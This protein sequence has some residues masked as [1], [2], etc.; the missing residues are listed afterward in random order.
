MLN[1]GVLGCGPIAQFAHLEACRKARNAELYAI[2]DVAK[3][4][5]DKMAAIH[6]PQQVYDDYQ[7]MLQDARLDA[8]I[9]ATSDAFH[10]P[11]AEM[12]INA[13]KHV[14][15]EKP[16]GTSVDEVQQLKDSLK[17]SEL[18][19]QVGH[20][21]RFD[22]GFVAAKNFVDHE[23]GEGLALKAWY[24]DSIF[25]YD[26]TDA[27]QPIPFHSNQSK[28]PKEDPKSNKQ[29]Y[30][31]LAHGSHLVDT[32]RFLGGPI[33]NVRARFSRKFGAY[34]WFVEVEFVN[35]MMGHLDLTIGVRM[36]WHEGFQIYGEHGSVLGKSFNPWYY[37]SSEV[38]CFYEKDQTYK[39]V[40]GSDAHFF[41]LQLE[42][43]SDTILKKVPQHGANLDDGLAS[44]K[45][46]V[47]IRQSVENNELVDLENVRGAV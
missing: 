31:M 32:A 13:G 42:G 17:D 6:G 45:A 2:C 18:V 46:M 20:M 3:D 47:A 37:K 4:L 23:M 21:K 5:R 19:L 43:F 16:I 30:Y 44:M 33:K 38:E 1:I 11:A 27:V 9:I 14:F 29:R 41:K 12:A 22:P 10:V 26:V 24:C 39:R 28:K 15:I 36:D 25:R 34:C 40:L 7:K 35:G 8:V